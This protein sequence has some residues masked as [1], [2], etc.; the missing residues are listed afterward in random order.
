MGR[1]TGRWL[2]LGIGGLA[3]VVSACFGGATV[4]PTPSPAPTVVQLPTVPRPALDTPVATGTGTVG[5]SAQ[6]VHVVQDGET[7]GRIA[8][9]YYGDANRWQKIYDANRAAIPNPNALT[10]GARLNIPPP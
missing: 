10:V 4:P 3:L 1:D 6:V 8:L 9:R 7:L 5:P 2:G